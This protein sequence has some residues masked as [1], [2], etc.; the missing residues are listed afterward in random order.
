MKQGDKLIFSS[1]N[2]VANMTLGKTYTVLEFDPNNGPE[3]PAGSFGKPFVCVHNDKNQPV[4][5]HASRFKP[6]PFD[7]YG[8]YGENNGPLPETKKD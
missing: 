7:E 6:T 8:F 1:G 4:M 3:W 2:Y 5:L